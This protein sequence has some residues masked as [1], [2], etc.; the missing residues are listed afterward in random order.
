MRESLITTLNRFII[1]RQAWCQS[2]TAG[3]FFSLLIQVGLVSKLI[4]QDLR[5]VR[6]INILGTTSDTNVQEE[7]V[8]ANGDFMKVFQGSGYVCGLA[9]EEMEKPI[10]L[11]GNWQQGKSMLLFDPLGGSSSTDNYMPL[12]AIF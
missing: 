7:T 6:L 10:S 3:G 9:P 1:E 5:R 12:G 4:A 2:A 11:L 8:I